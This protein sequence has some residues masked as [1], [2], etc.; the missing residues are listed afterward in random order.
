MNLW[1][2][3][4]EIVKQYA[5]QAM[6]GLTGFKLWVAKLL[7]KA[8]INILKSIGVKV[9]ERLKAEQRLKEYEAIINNPNTTP[10]ERRDADRNFLK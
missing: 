5:L 1:N 10:D 2:A 9:E 8:F 3:F 4:V 7:L 6:S